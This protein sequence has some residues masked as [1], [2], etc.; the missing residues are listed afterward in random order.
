M[1]YVLT[2]VPDFGVNP[3]YWMLITRAQYD[4]GTSSQIEY[5]GP[6]DADIHDLIAFV[7]S[8]IR[9]DNFTMRLHMN[10]ITMDD[11]ESYEPYFLITKKSR[12]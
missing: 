6:R 10:I 4:A 8:E 12:R 9:T 3:G 2:W 7:A 11:E 1:E 5:S